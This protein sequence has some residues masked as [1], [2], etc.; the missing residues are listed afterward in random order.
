MATYWPPTLSLETSPTGSPGIAHPVGAQQDALLWS[1]RR[2]SLISSLCETMACSTLSTV[3]GLS[4][5]SSVGHH[6]VGTHTHLHAQKHTYIHACMCTHILIHVHSQAQAH[7]FTCICAHTHA[8]KHTCTH[9]YAHTWALVLLGWE[10]T[11]PAYCLFLS[12]TMAAWKLRKQAG[13]RALAPAQGN[14][15]THVCKE[16][17]CE[18]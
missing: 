7:T 9:P 15:D 8:H 16:S 12:L 6:Q 17:I 2:L 5:Q 18:V 10:T 14:W 3:L 11:A 13:L 4:S 1:L